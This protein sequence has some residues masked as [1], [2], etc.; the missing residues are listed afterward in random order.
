VLRLF[1]VCVG[2]GDSE[3]G[4]G[5]CRRVDSKGQLRSS[6]P[7]LHKSCDCHVVQ[8]AAV[9]SILST[10]STFSCSRLTSNSV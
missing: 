5:T 6:S 1:D 10:V 8:A 4:S 2:G 9:R 7:V 3:G